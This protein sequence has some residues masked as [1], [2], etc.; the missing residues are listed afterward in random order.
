MLRDANLKLAREENQLDF[1]NS[2]RVRG[3]LHVLAAPL[4]S[5]QQLSEFIDE[6]SKATSELQREYEGINKA[7]QQLKA[8]CD[9]LEQ[10]LLP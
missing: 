2:S 10:K 4:H 3:G 1:E 7:G 6:I 9:E 8:A 5:P